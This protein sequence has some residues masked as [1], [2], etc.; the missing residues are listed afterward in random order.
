MIAALDRLALLVVGELRLAPHFHAPRL[1]AG[2]ARA[3]A[4]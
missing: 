1:G 3:G 4:L 2:G